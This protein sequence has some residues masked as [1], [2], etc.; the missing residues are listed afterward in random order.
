MNFEVKEKSGFKS[1]SN[2]VIIFK[3]GKP[4]YY[5]KNK[6]GVIRFNMPVGKFELIEGV[7]K[8]SP[9]INYPLKKIIAP[10]NAMLL[11]KKTTIVFEPNPNKC[12]VDILKGLVI[13]DT[14]FKDC[15]D[16]VLV[17]VMGHEFGHYYYRGYGQE[18]EK[19]CDAFSAN[20]MLTM[21]YNPSQ[22]NAAIK[23]ILSDKALAEIRKECLTEHLKSVEKKM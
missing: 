7:I 6:N 18:S 17:W 20:I 10:K 2:R 13:F 9:F 1:N 14:S 22:I 3:N 16:Y 11:P 12:S 15:P 5:R 21:G 4:F 8:K 23:E 19:A